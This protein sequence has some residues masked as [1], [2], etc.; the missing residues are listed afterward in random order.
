MLGEIFLLG[1]GLTRTE[2]A[3]AIVLID[4]ASILAFKDAIMFDGTG[5][6]LIRCVPPPR[7]NILKLQISSVTIT[8]L[9]RGFLP[10]S[11]SRYLS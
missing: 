9:V 2:I 1:G 4:M 3:T 7:R 11:G 8:M 5:V 10:S 6:R